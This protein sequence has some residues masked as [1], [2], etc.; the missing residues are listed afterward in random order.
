MKN[1]NSVIDAATTE[2]ISSTSVN[3]WLKKRG[4]VTVTQVKTICNKTV[5]TPSDNAKKMGIIQEDIVDRKSGEVKST[6]K[7]EKRAQLF[8][9]E[10]IEDIVATM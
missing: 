1:I 7:L 8:I 5:Y 3:K 6:I 2:K 10:N 4:F 9:L